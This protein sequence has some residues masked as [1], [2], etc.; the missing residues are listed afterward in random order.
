MTA[1]LLEEWDSNVL[2]LVD[3]GSAASRR[4]AE[5]KKIAEMGTIE[6]L[7]NFEGLRDEIVGEEKIEK[8]ARAPSLWKY[9][10]QY[11]ASPILE[12]APPLDAGTAFTLLVVSRPAFP[13]TL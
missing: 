8:E 11:G 7:N 6:V 13:N 9:R 4:V 10:E 3:A 2:L 12:A 1:R 5:R